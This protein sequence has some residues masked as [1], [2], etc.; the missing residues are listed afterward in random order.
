MNSA[1]LFPPLAPIIGVDESDT[2]GARITAVLARLSGPGD[3]PSQ[4]F[5]M[6]ATFG[7]A[8]LRTHGACRCDAIGSCPH[9]I[10][11]LDRDLWDASAHQLLQAP[12]TWAALGF[13]HGEGAPNLW[14]RD[15]ASGLDL[16]CWWRLVT[17][18]HLRVSFTGA[19]T[20][21][22]ALAAL[23]GFAST[24]EDAI[25]RARV[26]AAITHKATHT[27]KL[28]RLLDLAQ[29]DRGA[30]E[31]LMD[32]VHDAHVQRQENLAVHK[33]LDQHPRAPRVDGSG[34]I[35][36]AATRFQKA[37]QPRKRRAR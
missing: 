7:G 14:W 17:H 9:C 21:D 2:A 22:E 31:A 10:T 16:R 27:P 13:V 26:H 18:R 29:H 20:L 5:S 3:H 12:R 37:C 34:A 35:L 25:V 19:A 6:D 11:R 4:G 8:T 1:A 24:H 33:A 23:E 15:D 36:S 32:L 30:L 28:A